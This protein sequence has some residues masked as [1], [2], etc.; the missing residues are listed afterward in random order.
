VSAATAARAV[1]CTEHGPMAY[2]AERE[3]YACACLAVPATE[4]A[5]Y[6]ALTDDEIKLTPP[7]RS[8]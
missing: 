6:F 5:M 2:D 4:L 3:V 8:D 7:A 1:T